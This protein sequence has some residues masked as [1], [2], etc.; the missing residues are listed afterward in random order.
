MELLVFLSH[1]KWSKFFQTSSSLPPLISFNNRFSHRKK[2]E[3]EK[4]VNL[5]ELKNL[6]PFRG[7]KRSENQ[8]LAWRHHWIV[9]FH[10]SSQCSFSAACSIPCRWTTS[11]STGFWNHIFITIALIYSRPS[12]SKTSS[13]LAR[14][15][16]S[17]ASEYV[18]LG[19]RAVAKLTLF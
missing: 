17:N 1:L 4:D 14:G 13:T 10:L 12:K 2:K 18:K 6:R 7:N 16:N 15:K 3:T 11:D 9:G 19:S 8:Q 5:R